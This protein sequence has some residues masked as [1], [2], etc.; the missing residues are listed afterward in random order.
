MA[1]RDA[2]RRPAPE[3]ASVPAPAGPAPAR[4]DPVPA[5]EA[6]IASLERQARN[7]RA[8]VMPAHYVAM[9][10]VEA[11]LPPDRPLTC[12]VCDRTAPRNSLEMRVD[13]DMFG[14]GRLE[15]YVCAGCGCGFGPTKV[16]GAP[17][18]LLSAD[19]ALLYEDYAEGEGT[20][21]ERRAFDLL[22]L[23]RGRPV[24]NWGCGRWSQVIA[25]LRQEGWDAWGYE[26]SAPPA[27]GSFVVGERG[28][29]APVFEGLFSNNVIEHMVRPVEEFRFL[30][31]ILR[32]GA[33]MVHA[34]PC[35]LW[36]YAVSRYHVFFPLGD[37]PRVLAERSGFRAVDRHADGEFIAWTYERI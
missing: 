7:L 32:P 14:G 8:A 6:R 27:D 15:R 28:S 36:L 18:A 26:P 31:S 22:D 10:A 21:T 19:Y 20:A 25:R 34:S 23:P 16:A 11:G 1:L 12:P 17:E 3:P 24:L 2:F 9:D 13:Q 4:P 33:R 29:I 35:H 37:S 30:H 5:L